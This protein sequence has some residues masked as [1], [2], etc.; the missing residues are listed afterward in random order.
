MRWRWP[1]FFASEGSPDD[2]HGPLD[3]FWYTPLGART[4]TGLA[5]TPELA[6][7]VST[8]FACVQVIAQTVARLPVIVYERTSPTL[9]RRAIEHPVYDLLHRRPNGWQTSYE[10][11]ET[12]TAWAA[13][14]G[15]GYA[16]KVF[17]R[18]GGVR[19]LIPIHPRLVRVEVIPGDGQPP[20]ASPLDALFSRAET[21]DELQL[22]YQVRQRDGT[23]K[24]Y[25]QAEVVHIR[26]LSLDSLSGIAISD[27]AREAIGLAR[28]MEAYGAR[29][30]ANDGT[31][32]L[33][34][35]HPGT[36]SEPA[37]KRLKESFA[38][39]FTG[40]MNAWKPKILEEGMKLSRIAASGKEAQLT[41]ARAGQVIE[42][43][44]FYRMPPH[45]IQHMLQATF[46]NIESQAIEFVGDTIQ[47]WTTRWEQSTT[48]DLLPDD[49]QFFVKI[50]LNEA[51]RGDSAARA[52]YYKE[53]FYTGTLSRNE[54]RAME[55][56]NPIDGGDTYYVNAA[57]LP[58]DDDGNP[59]PV[60]RITETGTA[61]PLPPP[62]PAR[63]EPPANE[64]GD[65]NARASFALLLREAADRIVASERRALQAK[66]IVT[67]ETH[68]EYVDRVLAP[69][70][71]A[72]VVLGGETPGIEWVLDHMPRHLGS[73]PASSETLFAFLATTFTT[74]PRSLAAPRQPLLSS[75][76]TPCHS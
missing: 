7:Q 1:R 62:A 23:M 60:E 56:E 49:T 41:E 69:L 50:L 5:I 45:K 40:V 12:L 75:G 52:T 47:P 8:V 32:G 59:R 67:E 14:H 20:P 70:M 61:P 68:R 21:G 34:L 74:R 73:A 64:P 30:F 11:R 51:L 15:N 6:L 53:R 25:V 16:R 38:R 27:V 22:R 44:R 42:I 29:Y 55:G 19:E 31:I 76:I 37:H 24:P 10:F 35:E 3:D 46:S 26:G 66:R 17:D 13:L 18:A 65:E 71:A 48:R 43:C 33:T 58:L 9:R 57:T 72:W 28:A 2:G 36:L 63:P 39:G 54:I 4:M